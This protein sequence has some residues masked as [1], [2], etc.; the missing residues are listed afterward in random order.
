MIKIAAI[1]DDKIFGHSVSNKKPLGPVTEPRGG[2]QKESS[3]ATVICLSTTVLLSYTIGY[4][5]ST[6]FKSAKIKAKLTYS[7]WVKIFI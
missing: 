4:L 5:L 6:P 3:L 2:K 7:L 1:N